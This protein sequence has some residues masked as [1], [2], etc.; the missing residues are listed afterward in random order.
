[1]RGRALPISYS[2]A[3]IEDRPPACLEM[4][5]LKIRHGTNCTMMHFQILARTILCF[6]KWGF[7][8]AEQSTVDLRTIDVM[9]KAAG[10]CRDSSTLL[11]SR[12]CTSNC[13]R[14]CTRRSKSS[15]P[16]TAPARTPCNAH[17]SSSRKHIKNPP[18]NADSTQCCQVQYHPELTPTR[19]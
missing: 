10:I 8:Q 12:S 18:L 13:A 1:M 17:K 2:S 5:G 16:S 14:W 9:I 7:S 4:A 19:D 6:E 3:L 11:L 15:R